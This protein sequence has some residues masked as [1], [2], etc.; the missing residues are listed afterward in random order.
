MQ[1]A[2]SNR[3]KLTIDNLKF[4]F[5]EKNNS[6]LSY[7]LKESYENLGITL[8]ELLKAEE[9]TDL[10][11]LKRVRYKNPELI[12]DTLKKGSGLIL[13][14]A[15]YANWEFLALTSG[16]LQDETVNV[17]V[18]FQNNRYVD[19]RLNGIRRQYGNNIIDMAKAAREIVSI[20]GNGGIVALLAD[21]RASKDKDIYVEFFG[22]KAATY[23]A[24]ARLSVKYGTPIIMGFAERTS[25][26]FYEIELVEV[27]RETI[28]DEELSIEEKI[29][30]LTQTHVSMLEKQIRKR[31]ELWSWQ[32]DRWKY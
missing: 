4:A 26:G 22:R 24:P 10:E 14:S 20:L 2:D 5:P 32:H 30:K 21:K 8:C 19:K 6:E 23:D 25:D 17:I 7:I 11:L 29:E 15:H 31:P 1:M 3:T 9:L 12:G 18:K 28:K 16:I 13:L 27:Y